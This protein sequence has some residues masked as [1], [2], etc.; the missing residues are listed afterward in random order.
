MSALLLSLASSNLGTTCGKRVFVMVPEIQNNGISI[1]LYPGNN[2]WKI[3]NE[4]VVLSSDSKAHLKKCLHV[5][6][7]MDVKPLS[8][9]SAGHKMDGHKNCQKCLQVMKWMDT[10]NVKSVCSL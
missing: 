1:K 2:L 5:M 4:N 8:K 7:W 9:M 6:R 10:N 3:E